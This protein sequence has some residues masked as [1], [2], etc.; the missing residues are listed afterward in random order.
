MERDVVGAAEELGAV[1]AGELA[2]LANGICG[3]PSAGS[4]EWLAER[5]EPAELQAAKSRDWHLVK[6]AIC[7]AAGVGPTGDVINARLYGASWQQ[8]GNAL[9]VTRQA[10]HERW[11]KICER[12]T[13]RLE[14]EAAVLAA[15][16]DARANSDPV[17]G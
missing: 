5:E 17:G 2:R 11:G 14:S 10:A 7:V 9:G 12:S 1:I 6:I 3:R 4:S 8:I 15:A 16:D 13:V